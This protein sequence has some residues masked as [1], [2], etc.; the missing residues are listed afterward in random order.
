MTLR[1]T[2]L[3]LLLYFAARKENK[4]SRCF[5]NPRLRQWGG[6]HGLQKTIFPTIKISRDNLK[7][8]IQAIVWF[9][10]A[11][12]SALTEGRYRMGG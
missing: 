2:C 4:V 9:K 8:R 3:C 10:H 6:S 7:T 1:L 12:I 11:A 5:H